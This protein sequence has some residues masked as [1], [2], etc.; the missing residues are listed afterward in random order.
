[1][2][3][4][5]CERALTAV[6]LSLHTRFAKS[7]ETSLWIKSIRVRNYKSFED[8]GQLEFDRHMNVVIGTNHSGKSALL[9]VVRCR[10]RGIPHRSSKFGR[11]EALNPISTADFR[12]SVSGR[13][14]RHAILADNLNLHIPV[15]FAWAQN[16]TPKDVMDRFF[17]LPEIVMSARSQA[18]VDSGPNWTKLE[19]PSTNLFIHQGPGSETPAFIHISALESVRRDHA[20]LHSFLNM[21]LIEARRRNASAFRLRFSQSLA[22]RLQAMRTFV[23]RPTASGGQQIF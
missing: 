15:P 9:G 14:V 6:D 16:A 7:G 8:S 12:F 3:I 19:Y 11:D 2:I 13:E 18:A 22:R 4:C 10:Y 1:M 17:E 23:R 21:N 20:G 5:R